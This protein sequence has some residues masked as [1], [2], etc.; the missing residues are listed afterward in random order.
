MTASAFV[1][2]QTWTKCRCHDSVNTQSCYCAA[3]VLYLVQCF[4]VWSTLVWTLQDHITCDFRT[5]FAQFSHKN[6]IILE[7]T[8]YA[9]FSYRFHRF[10]F[11]VWILN[12]FGKG[13]FSD[14]GHLKEVQTHIGHS[15]A[16]NMFLHF[17]T[18]WPWPLIFDLLT[19]WSITILLC[20]ISEDHSLYQVWRLCDHS[21]LSNAADRQTHRQRRRK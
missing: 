3:R 14:D 4:G 1:S 19:F 13:I 9:A 20:R 16:F 12:I 7:I 6:R 18:M 10:R 17:V 11:Y 8:A 2:V 5:I 15:I 21:L